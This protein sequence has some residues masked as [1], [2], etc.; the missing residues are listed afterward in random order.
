ML[1]PPPLLPRGPDGPSRSLSPP[2]LLPRG[3]DGPSR[4]LSDK[5]RLR[6]E[7]LAPIGFG[8][9]E[10]PAKVANDG[11]ETIRHP[12]SE[13]IEREGVENPTVIDVPKF[14]DH[15]SF[16]KFGGV[17]SVLGNGDSHRMDNVAA[18]LI[19]TKVSSRTTGT[20]LETIVVALAS[21]RD[22]MCPFTVTN[23]L[24]RARHP[25]RLRVTIVDQI[26]LS[27]GSPDAKCTDPPVPCDEDPRQALCRYKDRIDVFT[28]NASVA[29]GPVFARH[30]G[31]RMYRGEYFFLQSDAHVEFVQD[32]DVDV[33]KQW[34]S[35]EN[36]M[37]VL[38][39]YVD[40]VD[41]YINKT[42]GERI[43][44]TRPIMCESGFENDGTGRHLR[45]GQQPD[46]VPNITGEPQM[47][48][49]WAAGF[50]FSRG[51]F[52]LNVPY[53]QH[54]PLVFQGE[55]V[56]IGIRGFTYGYDY[57]APER[58]I[59]YHYYRRPPNPL[60]NALQLKK[61]VAIP[62][63]DDAND[64]DMNVAINAMMR[65][66]GI[67]HM[68]GPKVRTSMWMHDEKAKYGIGNVRS[69]ELFFDTFGI[70]LQNQTVKDNLC[71]FVAT[72]EMHKM[73]KEVLRENKMGI[74]YDKLDG[75]KFEDKWL[76]PGWWW[77]RG[78]PESKWYAEWVLGETPE[79]DDMVG[80]SEEEESNQ[81]E[82]EEEGFDDR[83]YSEEI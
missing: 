39:S 7:F 29:N 53:D 55:E 23:I 30:I 44:H 42:T 31:N 75:F 83:D 34:R 16:K 80:S 43:R 50:S 5:P 35:T 22:W 74:D 73:F 45:H 21:Y 25:E 47:H 67:I 76:Q 41:G 2:P 8:A 24:E 19:G 70:N 79:E 40:E 82:E 6:R 13:Y 32:W 68:S 18:S 63:F 9:E 36:E 62:K 12:V 51:H 60:A 33:I 4:S 65:L 56:N 48:P 69:P 17:R 71:M 11:L 46:F 57:Y 38:T 1:R 66:N 58:N 15:E 78:D 26:D 14:W 10:F 61:E 54:L 28:L 59:L 27:E 3:P 77:H 72:G 37:A 64:Y 20:F 52:V 49:F 81:E